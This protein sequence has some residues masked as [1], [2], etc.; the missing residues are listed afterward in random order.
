MS[1]L[2]PQDLTSSLSVLNY[3]KDF[4]KNNSNTEMYEEVSELLNQYNEVI[5][6]PDPSDK[7]ILPYNRRDAYSILEYLKLQAEQLSGGKWTD[8]SDGDIGTIFLRM[9]AYLA[10]M[11][12][13]QI[14]KVVSELYLS[15]VTERAS[16]IAL[17]SLVGYE[18]RHYESAYATLTMSNNNENIDIP[19]GTIIPAYSMFTD[20]ANEIKFHNLTETT[21]YNNKAILDIYQGEHVSHSYTI[22]SITELGRIYLEEYNI[23]TNTMKLVI[24]G[25]EWEKVDDVRY[26]K[27][28][29]C[30]SIHI[31]VDKILYLQ[32]PAYWPDYITRGTNIKLDYLLSN[33]ENGRI[34]KNVITKLGAINSQYSS[35]M[36]IKECTSSEG[37]YNPETVEEMKDSVPKHARTMNTIVTINDFEE[38][39][40]F[41]S[42][43]SDI[44][45]LDYNDPA[46]GLI[47]PDDY[48]KVYLY[49][50]PDTENYDA[51]DTEALKYRNTI[52]K[53]NSDWEFSDMDN[54]AKDVDI[55]SQTSIVG[56]T[57]LLE[58]IL[59][60]Y[61]IDN[62]IPAIDTGETET[63]Y[64]MKRVTSFSSEPEKVEYIISSNGNNCTIT[65]NNGWRD[66]LSDTD[67]INIYYKQEQILTDIGQKLRNY[68]DERR[69][70]SLNV[71]YHDLTIVQPFIN[72]EI[73]MNKYDINYETIDLKVKSFI[74][75][76]YSRNNIKI[77]DPIFSSVMCSDI[78]NEFNCIR[79]CT[80][81]ISE[82]GE[83]WSNKLEVNPTGFIDI[84]PN[85]LD[86]DTLIDKITINK[87]DYQNKEI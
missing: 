47:Q 67:R 31:T 9:L 55:Y 36:L 34:G 71:T 66:L 54:V 5:E 62:I 37:G 57:I 26:A 56:N 58:G 85:Y 41:V 4:A 43:I 51:T 40:S 1:N 86:G 8:F 28:K 50:L 45:A 25:V 23:G 73:Y 38:V 65:L 29:L 72:I 80:V 10:D 39:G 75:D 83:N 53:D 3:L 27:G 19:D 42:G 49:V 15:T 6:E 35:N 2:T 13:F 52:I 44:S 74:L 48:Y 18:P 70:T 64:L 76:K 30:F 82:D 14:D 22:E 59:A 7:T 61:N 21:Y 78:L 69:L 87:N 20:S 11:N 60:L 16:A 81:E 79:Y 63:S 33:G 84:I 17:A 24:D 12:N 68:I 32:L 46:S 77:G